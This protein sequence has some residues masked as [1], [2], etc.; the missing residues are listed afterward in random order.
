[1]DK[2]SSEA[3]ASAKRIEASFKTIDIFLE[4]IEETTSEIEQRTRNTIKFI[5]EIRDF[6]VGD[7]K[8]AMEALVELQNQ[9]DL[10]TSEIPALLP[11]SEIHLF[12]EKVRAQQIKRSPIVKPEE[13]LASKRHSEAIKNYFD[14]TNKSFDHVNDVLLR[15][16]PKNSSLQGS[17]FTIDNLDDFFVF[18]KIR[19]IDFNPNYRKNWSIERLNT[20]IKNDWIT[21]RD[22]VISRREENHDR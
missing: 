11:E 2:V 19:T 5:D 6:S 18:Q 12:S 1:M 8:D 14:R 17:S 10:W 7:I 4:A 21:C 15:S 3:R 13:N 22:F 16:I 9:A 20:T